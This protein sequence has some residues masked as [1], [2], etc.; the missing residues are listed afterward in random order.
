APTHT[1]GARGGRIVWA[2]RRPR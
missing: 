1:V 2:A